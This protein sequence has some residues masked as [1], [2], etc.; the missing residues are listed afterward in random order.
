MSSLSIF[1]KPQPEGS[2][3]HKQYN[4]KKTEA[5]IYDHSI[6]IL[7]IMQYLPNLNSSPIKRLVIPV[8]YA[9]PKNHFLFYPSPGYLRIPISQKK[10]LLLTSCPIINIPGSSL[11]PKKK[12][13]S[14]SRF[15]VVRSTVGVL[16]SI[17][18]APVVLNNLVLES[19]PGSSKVAG[20]APTLFL[21]ASP[22]CLGL[23]AVDDERDAEGE[24][25]GL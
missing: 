15:L 8:V 24:K 9:H 2:R 21:D 19:L 14:Q 5:F 7:H 4:Q 25:L 13:T 20:A 18:D 3:C 10:S 11:P 22:L 1:S 23:L 16:V 6:I 17:A 12:L